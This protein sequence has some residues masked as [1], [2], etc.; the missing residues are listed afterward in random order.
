MYKFRT[1]H[2]NNGPE[3]T[4]YNDVRIT[5]IGKLLRRTKFDEFP[6]LINIIKGEMNFI[7]PRP[8]E[9]SAQLLQHLPRKE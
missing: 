6:Q 5:G 7:G 1:M 4:R 8:E 2:S 9:S 3:I